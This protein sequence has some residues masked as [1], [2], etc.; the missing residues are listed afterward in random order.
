MESTGA[1]EATLHLFRTFDELLDEKNVANPFRSE[2]QHYCELKDVQNEIQQIET[3][4][5]RLPAL[6]AAASAY[7]TAQ[8]AEASDYTE[9]TGKLT[10]ISE[11][12][13]RVAAEARMSK[14]EKLA[15]PFPE[16]AQVSQMQLLNAALSLSA[17]SGEASAEAKAA[18]DA[19]VKRLKADFSSE[20]ISA[21]LP[22]PDM[23]A[24]ADKKKAGIAG[25]LIRGLRTA[26]QATVQSAVDTLE[27][28]PKYAAQDKRLQV[29]RR[30]LDKLT[31]YLEQATQAHNLNVLGRMLGVVLCNSEKNERR[32]AV[33]ACSGRL[34]SA[35]PPDI[36]RQLAA[37]LR[38]EDPDLEGRHE[39]EANMDNL[40]VR[41]ERRQDAA[42]GPLR[43]NKNTAD[44]AFG[45]AKAA[46]ADTTQ[47]KVEMEDAKNALEAQRAAN[48][49]E[50]DKLG[51][52][53]AGT[54]TW[55]C[56]APRMSGRMVETGHNVLFISEVFYSPFIDQEVAVRDV[57]TV[58]K[59]DRGAVE[60][61]R[62][63]KSGGMSAVTS[64]TAST[65]TIAPPTSADST[66]YTKFGHGET[67]PSCDQCQ[68]WMPAYFCEKDEHC[69]S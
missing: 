8:S 64:Q 12:V 47:L 20:K 27:F 29:I 45:R 69:C 51:A 26:F 24:A 2:A 9:T 56:A 63:Q 4:V 44:R 17:T 57:V 53:D 58:N 15:D 36:Q 28:V 35:A 46:K 22:L 41:T 16:D 14:R 21:A 38:R 23:K 37:V 52:V 34:A 19:V 61:A 33:F 55:G 48:Q 68:K 10:Q 66:G 25:G 67:V 50:L 32:R 13:N 1:K 62:F 54:A 65:L 30:A 42:L 59:A 40:K 11:R 39:F 5:G 7:A 60:E 18:A 31:P 43:E 3:E 6:L 49:A